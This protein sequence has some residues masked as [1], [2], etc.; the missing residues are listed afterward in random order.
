MKRNP[1]E[2]EQEAIAI[3]SGVN[4]K[5]HGYIYYVSSLFTKTTVLECS[6]GERRSLNAGTHYRQFRKNGALRLILPSAG[7]CYTRALAAT[8]TSDQP[9]G[10]L[11][12]K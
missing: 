9:Q 4:N 7:K 11:S 5:H 8:V 1:A 6:Q 3:T 12:S 2:N 10:E